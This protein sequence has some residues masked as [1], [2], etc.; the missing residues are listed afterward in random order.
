NAGYINCSLWTN[1]TSWSEKEGNISVITNNSINT[2]A[3]T[4]TTDGTYLWNVKCV[5]SGSLSAFSTSNWTINIDSTAPTYSDN[6]TNT[7]LVGSSTLFVLKWED[8]T[9]LSGYIFSFDNGTGSFTNDS[10]VEFSGILNWSNVTKT[11]NNTVGSTIQWKVWSNDTFGHLAVSNTYSYITI[12]VEHFEITLSTPLNNTFVKNE[13]VYTNF[14]VIGTESTYNCWVYVKGLKNNLNSSTQNNT[15]TSILVNVS[16]GENSWYVNCTVNEI[17]NTSETRIIIFDI[18]TEIEFISPTENNGTTIGTT[19]TYINTT[20]TDDLNTTAF[21]DWNYSL[22]G[23]WRFDNSTDFLDH[24]SYSNDGTNNGSTYNSFGKFGGGRDFDGVDDSINC[25]NDSSLNFGSSSFTIESWIKSDTIQDG[26]ILYKGNGTIDFINGVEY[27]LYGDG[28]DSISFYIWDGTN[29]AWA[30][31]STTVFDG[32]WHHIVGVFDGT[33]VSIY[34]DGNLEDTMDATSVGNIDTSNND[35]IIGSTNTYTLGNLWNGTLDEVRLWNRALS[36]E[37]INASYNTRFYRLENNFTG[38][39]DG[40]YKYT[41]Y[42]QDLAGNINNTETRTL[43][44]DITPPQIIIY[45]PENITYYDIIQVDLNV[46]A[47]ETIDTWW[48]SLNSGTNTTFSPNVTI[49][50]IDGQNNITVY[51][52]DTVG[53]ENSITVFFYIGNTSFT[54]EYASGLNKLTFDATGY[55]GTF[56]AIN[57][58]STTPAINITNIGNINIDINMSVNTS[59]ESCITFYISEDNTLDTGSD[60]NITNSNHTVLTNIIEN[61]S[62]SLWSWAVFDSCT[63]GNLYSYALYYDSFAS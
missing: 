15:E 54:F 62:V 7:T 28:S 41:A 63:S 59:I 52:N 13:Y 9:N 10:F 42:V 46:S 56:A 1:E 45:S 2:I 61:A 4:F 3:E 11:V 21:I 49:N 23:L 14:T 55:S 30:D 37:E 17:S 38:L 58:N 6:S 36:E 50:I 39:S 32:N 57:Q 20:I 47:D 31:T 44:I 18:S 35:L 51:A 19:Y 8:A 40:T 48:Y 16:I 25:G 12:G 26:K 29:D 5:N 22:V 33:N 27:T 34:L 43:I 60:Y 24:S 53:N